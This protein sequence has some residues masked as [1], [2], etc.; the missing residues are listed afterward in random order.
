MK[1]SDFTTHPYSSVFMKSEHETIARNIMVIL[2][3]TGDEFR[4]LSWEEYIQER[5]KDGNFS[6]GEQKF[7]N[8]V[9]PY[10]L[11]SEVAKTFSKEWNK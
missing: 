3:R 8:D 5:E 11:N 6:T 4:D 9:K 7:F 2:E 10:T 1:P